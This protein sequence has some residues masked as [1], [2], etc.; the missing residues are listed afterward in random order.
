MALNA[1][2][3]LLQDGGDVVDGGGSGDDVDT[4]ILD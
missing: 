3:Q 4:W 1:E 2:V